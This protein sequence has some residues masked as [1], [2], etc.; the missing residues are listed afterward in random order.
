MDHIVNY[1][2]SSYW[3]PKPH[4]RSLDHFPGVFSWLLST[5]FCIPHWPIPIQKILPTISWFSNECYT[6]SQIITIDHRGLFY[7]SWLHIYYSILQYITEYILI[8]SMNMTFPWIFP[9][10]LKKTIPVPWIQRAR[11]T[12]V[13]KRPSSLPEPPL[14]PAMANFFRSA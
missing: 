1:K 9:T 6:I 12:R 10:V 4:H 11:R 7:N 13:C 2:V 5:S 3:H 8:I 14:A